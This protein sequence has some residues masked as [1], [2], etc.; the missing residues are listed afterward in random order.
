MLHVSKVDYNTG[1]D[2]DWNGWICFVLP[3]IVNFRSHEQDMEL[4][5]K[6]P[7]GAEIRTY[8]MPSLSPLRDAILDRE[9]RLGL[10][11]YPSRFSMDLC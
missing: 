4:R 2:V 7:R 5:E 10:L 8:E 1:E 6:N 3:R 11:R 9:V